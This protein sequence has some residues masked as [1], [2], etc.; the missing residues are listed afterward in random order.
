M[1]TLQTRRGHTTRVAFS[2][3]EALTAA[4]EFLPEAVLLDLGLPGMDGFEVARQIRAM[5]AL[6]GA[7][8]IAMTGYA[9]HEDRSQCHAAGFDEHLVKPIDLEVVRQRLASHP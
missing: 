2:G 9:S 7:L 8:L 1:A 3:P 4:A 5:P 6:K